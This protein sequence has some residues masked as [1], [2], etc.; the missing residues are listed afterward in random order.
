MALLSIITRWNN[1]LVS[2]AMRVAEAAF[3]IN[4]TAYCIDILLCW[5]VRGVCLCFA[6][7]RVFFFFFTNLDASFALPIPFIIKLCREAVSRLLSKQLQSH[8]GKCEQF[9]GTV[10]VQIIRIDELFILIIGIDK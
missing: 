1:E 6:C 5:S 2:F 10:H 3:A 4:S 8:F 9:H 7:V